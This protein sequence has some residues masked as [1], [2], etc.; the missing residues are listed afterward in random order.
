[1]VSRSA[2]CLWP[3]AGVWLYLMSWGNTP[4]IFIFELLCYS[5]VTRKW[6]MLKNKTPAKV[7]FI[8]TKAGVLPFFNKTVVQATADKHSPALAGAKKNR[9]WPAEIFA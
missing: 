7:K 5:C 1:M 9:G 8:L 6:F 2:I 4:E 3:Y